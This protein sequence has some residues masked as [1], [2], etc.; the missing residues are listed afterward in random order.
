MTL[1]SPDESATSPKRAATRCP[2]ATAPKTG[3][4]KVAQGTLGTSSRATPG[5]FVTTRIR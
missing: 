4:A 1:T 2:L 5:L 3:A